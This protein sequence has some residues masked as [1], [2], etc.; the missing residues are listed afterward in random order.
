[1][2]LIYNFCLGKTYNTRTMPSGIR[3]AIKR[4]N[5]VIGVSHFLHEMCRKA[6]GRYPNLVI[7]FGFCNEGDQSLVFEY[8]I[9]G[10]L[11]TWLL[12]KLSR[13]FNASFFFVQLIMGYLKV[14]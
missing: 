9:N 14:W 12:G 2:N 5:E 8:Y 10:D 7:T 3:A 6:K 13:S 1:M 4:F 11:T